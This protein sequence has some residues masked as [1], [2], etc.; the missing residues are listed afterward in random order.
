MQTMTACA[1]HYDPSVLSQYC[2]PLWDALKFEVLSA[3][4]P[5]LA[6]EALMTLRCIGACLS[7]S[8]NNSPTTSPLAL[9]LRPITKECLEHFQEPAQRQARASSDILRM[10]GA[11]NESSFD[12]I[13]KKVA[14]PILTIYQ[15]A[16][17]IVQQRAVLEIINQLFESAILVFGSWSTAGL[18]DSSEDSNPMVELRDQL[19]ALY[20]QALMGTIKE[21]VSLRLVAAKGLLLLARLRSFL[22]ENEIGLFVQYFNDIILNEESYGRDELKSTALSGLAEISK[23]KSRLISDITFPA[24]MARLPDDEREAAS[25]DYYG[26]LE[27]LAQ[28]SVEKELQE[29]LIRRLLN[30]LD[31]LLNSTTSGPFPYTCAVLSTVFY[32]MERATVEDAK[33]STVLDLYFDRVVVGYDRLVRSCNELASAGAFSDPA[34]LDLIG[35]MDSLIIRN[36]AKVRLPYVADNIYNLFGNNQDETF[37]RDN[38]DQPSWIVSTWLLAA[39][40]RDFAH[41]RLQA[42]TVVETIESLINLTRFSHNYHIGITSLRQIALYVNKH[43]AN[44]DLERLQP[45]LSELYHTV[46]QTL[47]DTEL[48]KSI[49]LI[50]TIVKALVL[51]LVPHT[52][53]ILSELVSL[54]DTSKYGTQ[55]ARFAATGFSSLL[56]TDDVLSPQNFAQIRLLA[57]Q[58]IFQTLIPLISEK[59]KATI[60]TEEK[61]NYLTALSGIVGTVPAEIIMPEMQTLLPLLLQSLDLSDQAVKIAT[62]ETIAVVITNNPAALEESG[63]IAA[64]VKRLIASCSLYTEQTEQTKVGPVSNLPKTKMLAARCLSLLP[65]HISGSTS[66]TNPLLALKKDVVYGLL[67]ALDDPR[68]DVRKEAVDARN[69]WIR[70]LDDPDEDDDD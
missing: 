46:A 52:N 4:E 6:E 57:P 10:V 42:V 31:I 22:Q 8:T 37:T 65:S 38:Q 68:R 49:R 44:S 1:E 36:S 3:Q 20:G 26:T 14:R 12:Y 34:A 5:E 69:T 64:L 13:V 35:R 51:R 59:F 67:K 19:I 24:F 41:S 55:T 63:H 33:T 23:A 56:S 61:Q 54:L 60:M 2:I 45:I 27:G 21:E 29:T 16:N 58:R 43:I 17:G 50:F 47:L 30:K 18:A 11:A 9:Y 48:S 15:S 40:P 32:L 39:L 53:T 70:N 62:L 7:R 28:I 66:R 25:T